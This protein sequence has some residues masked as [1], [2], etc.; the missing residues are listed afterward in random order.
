MSQEAKAPTPRWIAGDSVASKVFE[1]ARECAVKVGRLRHSRTV[2][3]GNAAIF[4]GAIYL[5]M[6]DGAP[7]SSWVN[8]S[9]DLASASGFDLFANMGLS[10]S[11]MRAWDK[12]RQ[13]RKA[14]TELEGVCAT[15]AT[16]ALKIAEAAARIEAGEPTAATR[17]ALMSLA[18]V[19][20]VK[21]LESEQRRPG[22]K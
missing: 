6:P 17:L 8:L 3:A 2:W 21:A 14:T 7:L 9:T 19:Q 1:V 22:P 20:G 12:G 5:A 15:L 18:K 11:L 10:F 13:L 16:P 4:M